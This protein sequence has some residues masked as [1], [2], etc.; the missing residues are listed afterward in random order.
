MKTVAILTLAV[1]ASTTAALASGMPSLPAG[2]KQLTK[3][4]II[5]LYDGKT[6]IWKNEKNGGPGTGTTRLDAKK[7]TIG[8][9]FRIGEASGE[10]EGKVSFKGDQYCFRTRGK[11]QPK[12]GPLECNLIFLDGTTA[13]EVNPKTKAVNSVNTPN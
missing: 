13:Y 8:G 4:E 2:A 12:Y 3:A 7:G 11:G 5:A 1:L 9:T 10:W 6:F